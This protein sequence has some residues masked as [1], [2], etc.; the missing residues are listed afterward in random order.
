MCK[1][2]SILYVQILSILYMQNLSILYVIDQAWAS[3]VVHRLAILPWTHTV[4]SKR[5]RRQGWCTR[6]ISLAESETARGK[7]DFAVRVVIFIVKIVIFIVKIT[8][9]SQDKRA[10]PAGCRDLA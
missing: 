4:F 7:R 1:I 10:G 8:V 9:C 5:N 3:I 2:L 6:A